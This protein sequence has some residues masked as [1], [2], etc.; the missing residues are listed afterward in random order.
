MATSAKEI[1]DKNRKEV[2]TKNGNTY[3]IR[4]LSPFRFLQIY[5]SLPL[6]ADSLS[7]D[8]KEM[9]EKILEE[10]KKNPDKAV[11]ALTIQAE[12]FSQCVIE[13]KILIPSGP[14]NLSAE[15]AISI[16]D[17]PWEDV[18]EVTNAIMEFSGLSKGKTAEN[19][20]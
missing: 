16:D 3:L 7:S 4:K 14:P 15:N 10:T 17:V 13:P 8:M 11:D 18:I 19:F 12:V 6:I 5:K 1:L 9:T 2:K 20:S